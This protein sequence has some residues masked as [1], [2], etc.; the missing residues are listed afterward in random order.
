MGYVLNPLSSKERLHVAE[1]VV[2]TFDDN[3]HSEV[4]DNPNDV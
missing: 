4:E 2:R 1:E 3:V